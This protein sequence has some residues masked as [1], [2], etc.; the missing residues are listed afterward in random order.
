LNSLRFAFQSLLPNA[1]AVSGKTSTFK[2]IFRVLAGPLVYGP[3]VVAAPAVRHE[4]R[5]IGEKLLHRVFEKAD[6]RENPAVP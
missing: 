4:A 2:L 1:F 5:E 3:I 6:G